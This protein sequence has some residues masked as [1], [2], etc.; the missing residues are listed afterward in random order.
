MSVADMPVI[1]LVVAWY[2]RLVMW[3]SRLMLLR[4]VEIFFQFALR[5]VAGVWHVF[6]YSAVF[7]QDYAA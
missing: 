3:L 5:V 4:D 6:Y 1:V 2:S 7:E